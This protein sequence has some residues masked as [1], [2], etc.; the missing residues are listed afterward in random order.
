M[1]YA[2]YSSHMQREESIEGQL[3]ECYDY[4]AK[5]G[6]TVIGEYVDRAISGKT[7]NRPDFQRLIKDSARGLFEAVVM[8]TLDR[9][10]RNRYDSAIYKAKLKKNGVK[11]Y[12]AK[13]PMP[14][15][16]E[17]II[18]ESVLEGYAEYYSE[19][20]ARNVKRGLKENAL[21]GKVRKNHVF[22]YNV[23][24]DCR[25]EINPDEAPVVKEVFRRYLSGE[26]ISS[27]AEWLVCRGYKNSRGNAFD[28]NNVCRMLDNEKYI[29]IYRFSDVV[30][31]DAVPPLISKEDFEK[32]KALRHK[33]YKARA[34]FKAKEEYLLSTKVFCGY[35]GKPMLGESGVSHTG[36]VYRYYKCFGQK[37]HKS[38]EKKPENKEWL[39]T[40]IVR[41]TVENVLTSEN[42]DKIA[43]KAV[44]ILDREFNDDSY[45][46]SL[47]KQLSDATRRIDNLI[48]AIEQGIISPTTKSRLAELES[49]ADNLR[50]MIG[51][52]EI[53][54]PPITKEHIVFWLESFRKGDMN[55]ISYQRRIIDTLINSVFVY[56]DD[57][58]RKIVITYNTS[59]NNTA[60]LK[61][62]D[63]SSLTRLFSQYPNPIFIKHC[64]C[65]AFNTS[66]PPA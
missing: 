43:S 44:E 52:E 14:D 9:F 35:C 16:P 30:L 61:S 59:G 24:P 36:K 2:R 39:E 15:T 50:G 12:Y 53:K 62:S 26:S 66:K 23:T 65:F 56:D 8:Y 6:M 42:I 20:L 46:R 47:E 60:T 32:V 31:E 33:N 25:Y 10:A 19:N 49:E 4:A 38:C 5:N 7:D 3:R 29:G 57:N 51:K 41:Y 21:N 55:D 40:V 11:V 48:S 37:K 45:L 58:D 13:Q 17:G 1:I 34:R 18:L 22:G 28:T 64:F 54:K 27:I 63:T